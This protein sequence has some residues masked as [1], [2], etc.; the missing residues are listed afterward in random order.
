MTLISDPSPV[1]KNLDDDSDSPLFHLTRYLPHEA[2][3]S[4]F[5]LVSV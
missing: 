2:G 3:V 4:L 5:R 1:V